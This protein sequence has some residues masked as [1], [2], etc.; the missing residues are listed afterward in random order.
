VWALCLRCGDWRHP[1]LHDGP[2]I[3]LREKEV[4]MS[5]ITKAEAAVEAVFRDVEA[6]VKDID[7]AALRDARALIAEAKAAEEKVVEVAGEYKSEI[8]AIAGTIATAEASAVEAQFVALA[9][10]L[11]ADLTG[12]FGE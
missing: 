9:E 12:L 11:F 7:G 1:E 3:T 6:G 8:L 4:A 5:F 2:P 10:R